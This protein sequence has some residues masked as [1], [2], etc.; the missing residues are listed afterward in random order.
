MIFQEKKTDDGY[1]YRCEEVFGIVEL[2]T[3]SKLDGDIL[4]RLVSFL[5]KQN[6]TAKETWGDIT[7]ELGEVSYRFVK[8]DLWSD[9]DEP[10]E[11][12]STS[13]NGQE[14]ESPRPYP[15][16]FPKKIESIWK[17]CKRFAEAFREAWK[18]TKGSE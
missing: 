8:A 4:D 15:W 7:T 11:N 18:S 12:I 9:D 16:S 1:A 17:W 14:N 10:C 2:K 5:L 6:L 3:E 13:T